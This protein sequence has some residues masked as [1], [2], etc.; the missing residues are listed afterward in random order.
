ML[1]FDEFLTNEYNK[2]VFT[3]TIKPGSCSII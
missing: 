3:K 1:F 2:S